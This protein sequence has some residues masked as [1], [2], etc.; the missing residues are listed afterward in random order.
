LGDDLYYLGLT[1]TLVSVVHALY[2]F[3]GT[4]NVDR[5]VSDFSV[6]LLTTL[7]GIVGRILLYEKHASQEAPTDIDEGIVRLGAEI[8]D[9]VR[10]MQEFRR[11]LVL[12][13]QQ[14]SDSVLQE[15]NTTFASLATSAEEMSAAVN[16]VNASLKKG[17]GAFDK[18]FGR[19]GETSRALTE[20][21]VGLVEGTKTL[22]SVSESLNRLMG[23]LNSSVEQQ[24]AVLTATLAAQQEAT[25]RVSVNLDSL[26][27]P[28]SLLAH[29]I[30]EMRQQ[31]DA[32][33]QDFSSAQ[34][35]TT[36]ADARDAAENLGRNLRSVANTVA[37]AFVEANFSVLKASAAALTELT[38][39]VDD[40][41]RKLTSSA[42][43]RNQQGQPELQLATASNDNSAAFD[44]RSPTGIDSFAARTPGYSL[45]AIQEEGVVDGS[46]ASD[47]VESNIY[48]G[49]QDNNG[50]EN[51]DSVPEIRNRA[52]WPWRRE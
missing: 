20:R 4:A 32:A 27:R 36:I 50:A 41:T 38:I 31:I 18:S 1:Y 25:R 46:L 37:P 13:L 24:S 8:Q 7:A 45:D 47:A 6:A 2:T 51:R 35:K 29:S 43:Q 44:S 5:L 23:S 19:I 30:D 10:Y 3:N 28:V 42:E 22:G 9:A 16:A 39:K 12:N 17:A 34:L 40:C 49:P 21:V 33:K 14:S 11:G 48:S 26:N 15:V 52:W